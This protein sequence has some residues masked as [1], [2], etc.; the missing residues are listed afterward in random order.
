[1]AAVVD[2]ASLLSEQ[3]NCKLEELY[4]RHCN[5]S[6]EGTVAFATALCKNSTLR[7]V[8]LDLNRIG[9]D[10]AA[11][12]SQMLSQ[13]RTLRGI[14]LDDD[15]MGEEGVLVFTVNVTDFLPFL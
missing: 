14:D 11:A 8:N 4:L 7:N 12:I 6:S 5:I 13:N 2:L 9:Q 3:S 1:M 15:S 10:G